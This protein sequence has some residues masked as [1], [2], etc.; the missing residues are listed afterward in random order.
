[1]SRRAEPDG[2]LKR[3]T[4]PYRR[5][6]VMN[7]K[8]AGPRPCSDARCDGERV[9]VQRRGSVGGDGHQESDSRTVGIG[10]WVSVGFGMRAVQVR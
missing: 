9:P 3:M 10:T 4:E 8:N 2:R 5:L 1:M 7:E 6:G